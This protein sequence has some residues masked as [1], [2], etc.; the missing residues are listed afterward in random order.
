MSFVLGTKL[1]IGPIQRMPESDY[2]EF[3]NSPVIEGGNKYFFVEQ[4][5][6][7]TENMLTPAE[8]ENK[9]IRRLPFLKKWK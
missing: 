4:V 2:G 6:A 9:N 3:L 7:V 1:K 8:S 5:H